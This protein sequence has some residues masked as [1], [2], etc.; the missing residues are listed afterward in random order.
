METT[1]LG[2]ANPV[3][4][5]MSP[6]TRPGLIL[7]AQGLKVT[8]LMIVI[9]IKEMRATVTAKLFLRFNTT[10]I[11]HQSTVNLFTAHSMAR[12]SVNTVKN[13]SV[14]YLS[15]SPSNRV[16]SKSVKVKCNA[17]F[18]CWNTCCLKYCLLIS[19][20]CCFHFRCKSK[21]LLILNLSLSQTCY[22]I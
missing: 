2:S 21:D 15:L 19:S 5:L 18:Y 11:S 3:P 6:D 17:L 20:K 22:A 8:K 1:S 14:S 16:H 13:I 12:Y 4:P 9:F 10:I 7:K